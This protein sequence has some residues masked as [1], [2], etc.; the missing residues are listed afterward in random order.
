M[1]IPVSTNCLPT[2]NTSKAVTLKSKILTNVTEQ[3]AKANA[4]NANQIQLTNKTTA[5][6]RPGRRSIHLREMKQNELKYDFSAIS[7]K[8]IAK[9]EIEMKKR[10]T[11]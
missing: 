10:K 6:P 2:V 1:L 9:S 3:Q 11:E 4:Q 7:I 5:V 8:T